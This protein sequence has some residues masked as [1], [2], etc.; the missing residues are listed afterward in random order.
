MSIWVLR[1]LRVM[2]I[3]E[4]P[5]RL[6]NH[7]FSSSWVEEV[8]VPASVVEIG[9]ETFYR[10]AKLRRV[11][12]AEGS[13]LNGVGVAAFMESGLEELSLPAS[14]EVIREYAFCGSKC[15]RAVRFAQGSLL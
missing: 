3:P 8:T 12:F 6:G 13:Q 15:F 9:T 1:Y 11:S 5:V 4:G 10:C 14:V 7:W 2:D